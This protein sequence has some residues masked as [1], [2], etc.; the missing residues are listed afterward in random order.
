MRRAL[1]NTCMVH[2]TSR[3]FAY[4]SGGA[5]NVIDQQPCEGVFPA[6]VQEAAEAEPFLLLFAARTCMIVYFFNLCCGVS[7]LW[8]V[9]IP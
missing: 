5:W 7:N 3:A 6:F 2:C 9:Q 8:A 4:E 1:T